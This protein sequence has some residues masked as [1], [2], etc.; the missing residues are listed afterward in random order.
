[1]ITHKFY[2]L[3]VYVPKN[4]V[5]RTLAQFFFY[6]MIYIIYKKRKYQQNIAKKQQQQYKTKQH[7]LWTLYTT[8]KN[9]KV[10]KQIKW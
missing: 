7:K 6:Q 2:I 3:Y 4:N 5:S 10:A 9:H 8:L 1:M